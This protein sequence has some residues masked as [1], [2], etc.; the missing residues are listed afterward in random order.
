[1]ARLGRS[2]D[3]YEPE[4][5]IWQ[6][7]PA[8]PFSSSEALGRYQDYV[9]QLPDGRSFVVADV[10]VGELLGSVSLLANEPSHLKVEIGGVWYT[11]PVQRTGVNGEVTHL[12]L[13]H[14]FGLGYERVEWK[15][16][17]RNERSRSAALRMGFRFEGV[18]ERHMIQKNRHR[19]TAWFRMFRDEWSPPGNAAAR[20]LGTP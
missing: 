10:A 16:H 2:V 6:F 7:M 3:A 19:D 12:V 14:V 13:D 9:A 8:G 18:H 17:A 5:L 4:A 1:M 20:H 15:C 11:P